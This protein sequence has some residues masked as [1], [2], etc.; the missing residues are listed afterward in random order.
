MGGR[1]ENVQYA[2][3]PTDL[4]LITLKYGGD[5]RACGKELPRGARAHWSRSSR[6]VWCKGC[7]LEWSGSAESDAGTN[8]PQDRWTRLCRYLSKCVLAEAANTLA[9]YRDR[10]RRWFPH[11]GR[12]ELMVTGEQDSTPVPPAL[13]RYFD[14]RNDGTVIYGW[15]TLVATNQKNHPVI[16]PLFL[17][18]VRPEHR[19]GRWAADAESE[20]E[21]NLS[22]VAGD[23][24]DLAMKDEIGAVVGDGLPFG[25]PSALVRVASEISRVLKVRI[26]SDLD[27]RAL[28]PCSGALGLHN[29]AV[30]VLADEGYYAHRSLLTELEKLALRRNWTKTAA[31]CLVPARLNLG[32][33]AHQMQ[34]E[35][36]AA[37]LRCNGSQELTLERLRR[38]PLT[39]VTG[40]PGTGKTQLVVNAVAN[41]WLDGE[42]VLVASTNNGAV[43]VAVDRA[44]KIREGMLLR[45][46]NRRNV[47]KLMDQIPAL[48]A[49]VGD[50]PGDT[51]EELESAARTRAD[52]ARAAAGRRRLL[53]DLTTA[54]ELTRNLTAIVEN[55]KGLA[56]EIWRNRVRVPNLALA[57]RIIR[58]W[59]RRRPSFNPRLLLVRLTGCWKPSPRSNLLTRWTDIDRQRVRLTTVL[60]NVETRIGDAGTSLRRADNDW[61][62]ASLKATQAAVRDGVVKGK[63][64]LTALNRVPPAGPKIMGAIRESLRHARGWACTALSMK[65]NFRLEGGLFDLVIIDEASQ[66]SLATALPLAYRAKR[67]AVIGD[68][69]QLSPIVTLSDAW[70]RRIAA[71][72]HF[73]D[74]EL[75]SHGIQ[76][77][78]GSTYHAFEHAGRQSSQQPIVLDEHYRSHPLIARWFNKEFY[79]GEL[80]VLTDVAKMPRNERT[81][82]W[83]DVRSEA[84]RGRAG[85]WINV[86]EAKL[87]VSQLA[88]LVRSADG[89][90]GVVTPFS[91]QAQLIGQL[92]RQRLGKERLAD[93]DF[94]CGTA[95]RFQGGEKDTIVFSAVLT[96]GISTRTAAWVER[97][98]NLINVAV[99]RARNTLI[100]LGHP[101]IAAAGSRTL[102]SL[103]DYLRR[104]PARDDD[105]NPDTGKHR[106]D[107]E[108]EARLLNAMRDGGFRPSAKLLVRGYELDFA[109]FE[110]G[111]RLN[112]EVDGAHHID[113][114]GKRRRQDI[115]RDRVIA[116]MGW[117]VLRIPAWRCVWDIDGVIGEIRERV[118]TLRR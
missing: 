49:S 118:Q 91:A 45:T 63:A 65:R 104:K 94:V 2:E 85:S 80:T 92:A 64:T 33:A 16:A 26:V 81:I 14:Q 62:E 83:I 36:T 38:E 10:D 40:P 105:P 59:A 32:N 54:A 106:T 15:P 13:R 27:P 5:C 30:W 109:L 66:C 4:R 117:D 11:Y 78:E 68:P 114:R 18:P 82:G 25:D 57:S 47:E 1:S 102:D 42:T 31:A 7:I 116:G 56:R 88:N 53:S 20:P 70:L 51:W 58:R 111:L 87:A 77:K 24:F 93:V 17:V 95:H 113:D 52:L 71:S 19:Q 55:M 90:A 108:A 100:V 73:D 101:E 61:A 112:V 76:H 103:R 74:D 89:S 6:A 72:D 22:I 110:E 34:K 46:G 96:P 48:V 97:E 28:Q 35:A 23:L 84:R 79:R 75:V 67:L 60:S 50:A 107:S 39:V 3:L 9:S 115:V 43:D 44:G 99:S 41:A 29:A 98:R 21:L 12:S 8:T 86:A 37:P 69:N